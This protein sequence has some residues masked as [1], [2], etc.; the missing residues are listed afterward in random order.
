EFKP[1]DYHAFILKLLPDLRAEAEIRNARIELEN[2]P[3][4]IS[5]RFN[6]KLLGRV[7]YNLI[8]NAMDAMPSGGKILLRFH[9]DKKEIITEIEDTGGGIAPEIADKLFQNF[10][11]FGKERG[12]GLGL[13]I[14][15]K[16]VGDHGGRIWAQSE[17]GRGAIFCFSLPLAK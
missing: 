10:A 6:S 15:K 5:P 9:A 4:A 8:Y 11:T 13:S 16:I 1:A 7:F 3:P 17:R 2:E 14:C 12:T